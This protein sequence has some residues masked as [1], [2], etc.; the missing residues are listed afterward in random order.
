MHFQ[1]PQQARLPILDQP[2]M[3]GP[4]RIL[5]I[6]RYIHDDLP[7]AATDPTLFNSF[8]QPVKAIAASELAN[9]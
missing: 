6:R 2:R 7:R 8:A 4:F 3:H 1:R 5:R 9:L